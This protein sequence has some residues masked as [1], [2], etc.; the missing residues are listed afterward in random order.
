M[1]N[2]EGN[3]KETIDGKRKRK[4]RGIERRGE[5]SKKKD[6]RKMKKEERE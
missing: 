3:L 4:K 2:E 1:K 5:G 6:K